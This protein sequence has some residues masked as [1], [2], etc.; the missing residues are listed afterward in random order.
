[1]DIRLIQIKNNMKKT[2]FL[3]SIIL[4][5]LFLTQFS[6]SQI[7]SY[8]EKDTN[9]TLLPDEQFSIKLESNA[10]TG[11][12]WA[13]SV[14]EGCG[15][16]YILG[17]EYVSLKEGKTGEGGEQ[18]WRFKTMNGGVIQLVFSYL[19]PWEEENPAKILKFNVYCK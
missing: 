13:V 3:F 12:S 6:F 10:T 8:T 17:S 11:Y 2:F 1:M 15:N 18:I 7:K 16:I 5:S 9:I 19:R 4:F 14:N